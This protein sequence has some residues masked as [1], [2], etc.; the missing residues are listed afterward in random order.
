MIVPV[1]M[2]LV[3]VNIVLEVA[4]TVVTV[5]LLLAVGGQGVTPFSVQF[6]ECAPVIARRGVGSV[7]GL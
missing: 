4:M 5:G 1:E 6:H 2:A 7:T 3:L